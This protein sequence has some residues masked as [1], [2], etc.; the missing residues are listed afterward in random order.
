MVDWVLS[1]GVVAIMVPG[2]LAAWAEPA[3]KEAT[4]KR[5]TSGRKKGDITKE[6]KRQKNSEK[7]GSF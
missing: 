4:L 6:R 1:A 7:T 5:A 2:R 3:S